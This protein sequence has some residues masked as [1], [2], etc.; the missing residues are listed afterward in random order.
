MSGS[1][2]KTPK[3]PAIV[4]IISEAIDILTALGIPID[5][6]TKRQQER[7]AMAFLAVAGII[8]HWTQAT[9]KRLLK[10]RD[11]IE[12]YNQHFEEN[13]SSGSYDDVRRKDLEHIVISG[14]ILNQSPNPNAA[15][16]DPTRGYSLSPE[17]S[18][19]IRHYGTEKWHDLLKVYLANKTTLK[20]KLERKRSLEKIF[21]HLS[22][23]L[24]LILSSGQHNLLQKQIIEEFLPRYGKNSQ[25]LYLGDT[26]QKQLYC[27]DVQLKQLQFF[28]L[29]HETLPDIIA[30][31]SKS[32]WLYV[33]EA[34]HS[35]GVIDELR[36][37]KLQELTKNCTA[38]IIYIT[39]FLNRTEFRKWAGQ[40]AWETEV[41][42]ADNPDHLIHFNGHKFL[43]P[44]AKLE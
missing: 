4:K 8:E 22:N 32:N 14:I 1:S 24:E 26:A 40:I 13:I 5:N 34:V 9:D 35:S 12:F 11:I 2:K 36:L 21:I 15:T 23:G 33:I 41:W 6:Q 31:D 38:E 18:Q 30:Y 27:D 37:L 7:T 3:S 42:I 17:I 10:T 19:L 29:S 16:N 44:Y 28:E 25:I 39:A 43:G 20:E